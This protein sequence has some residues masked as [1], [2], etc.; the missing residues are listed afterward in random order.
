VL[1]EEAGI[2]PARYRA[3]LRAAGLARLFGLLNMALADGYIAMV[4]TKNHYNYW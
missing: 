3:P 2:K 1:E 4:G